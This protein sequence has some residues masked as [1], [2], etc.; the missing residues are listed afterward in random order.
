MHYRIRMFS[1][2]HFPI[3]TR[4]KSFAW[5]D[6]DPDDLAGVQGIYEKVKDKFWQAV[7]AGKLPGSRKKK[8]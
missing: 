3:P 5:I 4:L 2:Q 6:Y 8:K 7:Q 1:T